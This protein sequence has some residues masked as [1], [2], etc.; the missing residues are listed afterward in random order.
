M[1]TI[2]VSWEQWRAIIDLLREKGLRYMLDHATRIGQQ[3][4]QHAPDETVVSLILNDD[5]YL[6][7]FTWARLQLDIPLPPMP[8]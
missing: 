8:R 7:S 1:T 6:R 3:L 5:V 2:T 4:D